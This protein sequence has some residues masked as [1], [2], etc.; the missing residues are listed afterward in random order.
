MSEDNHSQGLPEIE[1][2][3]GGDEIRE[4]LHSLS[5]RG[6]LP[7]F[8]KEVGGGL[9]AVA[10]H[11]VPFDSQLLLR[12][13]GGRLS[14]ECRLLPLMPRLFV[15]MMVVAVWPGLP[16]TDSFLSS[17]DWYNSLMGSLRLRT[18]YWYLPLTVVPLPFAFRGALAKSRSSA[19]ESAGEQIEKIRSVL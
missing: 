9:C 18:W 7:G 6:K 13:E 14:F 1:T 8:E 5:K 12:L 15:L 19:L 2:E 16:L 10:A 3:L 4:R 17:F 11:G